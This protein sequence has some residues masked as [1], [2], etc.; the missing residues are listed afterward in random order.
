MSSVSLFLELAVIRW[1]SSEIRIFAYF[2]NLPLMAAFLGFGVGFYL[3]E[4]A[5]RLFPWF[6]RLVC[7]LTVVISAAI[8]FGITHIVF[9]DPLQFFLLGG[10]FSWN[11]ADKTQQFLQI[12]KALVVIVSVFFLVMMVFATLVAKMG[13]ILNREKPLIGYSINIGGSLLGIA[14]FSL[15]SYLEWPPILWLVLVY[16]PLLY[17]YRRRITPSLVYF[18]ASLIFVFLVGWLNPAIWSP[19][20]RVMVKSFQSPTEPTITK[21][22][23]NYDGFQVIEDLSFEHLKTYPEEIQKK[24]NRHYNIPY[25]LSRKKIESVLILGGGSGN[26]AAAA[27]RNGANRVDVVEIDPVIAELGRSQH[28]EKP[29][30]SANVNLYIDDARS[31]L[32][33]TSQKYDLVVFATLDSHTVFS[34]LSSLRLDNFVFTKES[35]RS[36][37]ILL[38][39]GGGIAINFLNTKDWLF[40]RHFLTLSEAT[41][42]PPLVYTSPVNGEVILL[43]GEL[44]DP[45]RNPGITNYEPVEVSLG[46]SIVEATSDD[47]PFLFLQRRGV[48]FHYILPLSIIL[49]LSFVPLYKAGMRFAD[50]D[51]HLFS[52]G[53]AF[54]LIETKAVTTLALI[55]GSTWMVNA[56]VLA[57][58]MIMILASNLVVSKLSSLSFSFLYLGLLVAVL[59]NYGF[60]FDWLNRFSWEIGALTSGSIIALPLFFASLIFAKAF[61]KVESPSSALASNLLGGLVGGLLEYLDMW[62]GLRTLNLIALSL[63][64]ISAICL[65]FKLRSQQRFV[66]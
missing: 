1:L 42:A 27:L 17:F 18:S 22:L 59:F 48:P 33:K 13:E 64:L 53:A 63:Y 37:S 21:V 52:M 56:V 25:F 60:S 46:H 44:F 39:P 15:V 30:H 65:V 57:A 61:S 66:N 51:W 62:M 43:G 9:V 7:I 49:M 29:Y 6:P 50:V 20:Y 32:Q 11:F 35:V 8:A 58:I 4:K 34:S 28:P 23:V 24:F 40:S 12:S 16:L 55:F 19:Y 38:N 54:L 45:K 36:A 10:G 5:D 14:T 41:N 2:K 47:W 26:D 3:H 31:F